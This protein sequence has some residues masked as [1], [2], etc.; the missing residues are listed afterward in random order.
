M[1]EWVLVVVLTI[2]SEQGTIRD[3]SLSMID[4]F[5]TKQA[6]DSA[7]VTAAGTLIDMVGDARKSQGIKP[8]LPSQSPSVQVRCMGVIK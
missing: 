6:C 5:S 3:P 7:A 4:G 1:V 2:S 8:N